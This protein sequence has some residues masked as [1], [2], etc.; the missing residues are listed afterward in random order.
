MLGLGAGIVPMR[1]AR[2][3]VAVDVVDIDPVSF[4]IAQRYFGFEPRRVNAHLQDART[5]LRECGKRYDVILVD[6][7]HGDGMPEYL[8]TREFFADVKACLGSGGVAA[9]NGLVDPGEPAAYA[10]FLVTLRAEFPA[11]TVYRP[12][13]HGARYINSFV[14]AAAAA[15]PDA[16]PSVPDDVIATHAEA[17]AE[18]LRR[19]R[20]LDAALLGNGAIVTDARNAGA[21]ETARAQ[22]TYRRMVVEELPGAFLLN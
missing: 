21:R 17:L 16:V 11:I 20:A 4:A 3:G 14:V 22:L 12:L 13:D 19:P 1:L 7:F 10:H 15:L 6:L 2:G 8:L 18:M 5:Y 9:F